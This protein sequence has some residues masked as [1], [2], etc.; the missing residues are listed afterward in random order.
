MTELNKESLRANFNLL[1]ND[2]NNISKKQKV[3]TELSVI[4]NSFIMLM[5]LMIAIFMEKKVKKTSSNSHIPSSQT[6]K[7]QSSTQSG[8]NGKGKKINDQMSENSKIKETLKISV[9]DQCCHCGEDLS[10]QSSDGIER[11]TKIDIFFEKRIQHVDAEIKTCN[12]CQEV[13]KGSFPF[14]MLGPLQYGKGIRAFVINL[15][16]GQFIPLSRVQKTLKVLIGQV[17]SEATILKYVMQLYLNLEH[18]EVKSKEEILISKAMNCDETSLRV[19]K[20]KQWI[21][22]YSAGE[23]TLKFL[24]EKRGCEAINDIGIIPLYGGTC[25]HDCWSAYLSYSNCKH[26]LCGSHLLRELQ[27]VIESN[28]YRWAKNM[29]KLLKNT[30]KKVSKRKKKKLSDSEYRGLQKNFRNIITRGQQ[31]LPTIITKTKKRGRI[32][33]SDAHNLLERLNVHEESV[34]A[35]TRNSEVS[36]T[37]NRAERDLRMAKVKQKVSGCFRTV[38]FARAYCRISSYLQTM[39][40][41]GFHP[42]VAIQMA[43]NGNISE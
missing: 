5:E 14:D 23:I 15:L 7:D 4:F 37:N 11:R 33:K 13:T 17:I 32:A 27:F 20:K 26:G 1:K 40:N 24:H 41:K 2:F 42:M 28:N 16:I 18:W 36:F 35:F 22:S 25:I 29:K 6:E 43:L 19:V 21:H 8:S 39:E 3:S 31:E 10:A 12:E 9:V 30:A 34:L 38:E